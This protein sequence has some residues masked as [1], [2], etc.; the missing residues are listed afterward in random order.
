MSGL[1]NTVYMF[2]DVIA[3]S[4]LTSILVFWLVVW[5]VPTACKHDTRQLTFVVRRPHVEDCV[6]VLCYSM[7]DPLHAVCG[8]K[9]SATVDGGVSLSRL[10]YDCTKQVGMHHGSSTDRSRSSTLRQEWS[11]RRGE[12]NTSLHFF[13][14]IHWLRDP[15]VVVARSASSFFIPRASHTTVGDR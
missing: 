11:T 9:T 3:S 10:D 15:I 14:S 5:I 7:F 6:C 4:F 1:I 2:L 8:H 13:M 12:T